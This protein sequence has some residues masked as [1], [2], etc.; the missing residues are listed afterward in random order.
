[1]WNTMGGNPVWTEPWLGWMDQARDPKDGFLP[2][3]GLY[4]VAHLCLAT[5][6][7]RCVAPFGEK[8][9]LCVSIHCSACPLSP[10]PFTMSQLGGYR[11]D[12]EVSVPC[13]KTRKRLHNQKKHT[14]FHGKADP[15]IYQLSGHIPLVNANN[16]HFRCCQ[17]H[18]GN[19]SVVV[20]VL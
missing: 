4:Q 18:R 5:R 14:H 7:A 19:S 1:M 17:Y 13:G 16:C 6:A 3:R 2:T 10:R 15:G 9:C 8:K 12:N 11:D 20:A